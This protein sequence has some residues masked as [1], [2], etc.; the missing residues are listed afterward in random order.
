MLK[1]AACDHQTPDSR[2]QSAAGREP[3]AAAR[4]QTSNG[5]ETNDGET[6]LTIAGT[7][8]ENDLLQ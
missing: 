2:R 7:G 4:Q 6:L 3:H 1:Q 8:L 5:S